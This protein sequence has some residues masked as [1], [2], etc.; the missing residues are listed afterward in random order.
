MTTFQNMTG[1]D[2]DIPA[3]GIFAP[4]GAT[5]DVPDGEAEGLR[6]QFVE[7]KSSKKAGSPV[8][9]QGEN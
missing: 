2:I 8:A 4:A 3:L 5:F 1:A 9:E 6:A 7:K